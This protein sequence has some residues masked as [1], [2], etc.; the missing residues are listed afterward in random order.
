MNEF[1]GATKLL[2]EFK[3]HN[4]LFGGTALSSIG[5]MAAKLG[6]RAALVHGSKGIGERLAF[7]RDNLSKAGVEII[8]DVPGA[9]PNAPLEDLERISQA[10]EAGQP[11]LIIGFGAGSTLDCIKAAEVLRTI[12]GEIEDYF[13][14]GKVTAALAANSKSLTPVIAIQSAASSASHLTKYANI[15][16]LQTFQKKLIVDDAVVPARAIFDYEVTHTSPPE[17]TIDGALD[18][19]SHSLEVLYGAVG[20]ESYPTVAKI[21][22]ESIRLVVEYLPVVLAEPEHRKGREALGLATDLGGYAIMLGGTNGA[23]LNSFS[24]VDVLSHGRACGMLNP[25]YTVF[26]APA[27][28][29]PMQLVGNIF[30]KAGYTEVDLKRLRGHALGL[31]LAETMLKF[32]GSLGI[33]TTLSE[34]NGF[35]DAH[36]ERAL[37]AAKNPQLSMKLQNMPV[38][39]TEAAIDTYMRPVLQAALTGNLAEIKQFGD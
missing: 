27:I 14:S 8:A 28:Q 39:L 11:D 31:A 25:Y 21:A 38:P 33:A 12:G 34:V 6:K 15:T 26:F 29:E 2:R 1:D 9:A 36:I 32:I 4:Y 7:A 5:K 30:S 13:G 37:Q 24:F 19:I 23:H 35:Q 22:Q 3:Q 20:Q 10:F 17:L 16:N 18:G